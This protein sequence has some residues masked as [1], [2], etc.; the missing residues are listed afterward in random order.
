MPERW[1]RS[2]AAIAIGIVAVV[3]LALW[4]GVRVAEI[5]C[6][7]FDPNCGA[8]FVPGGRQRPVAYDIA[9]LAY[10]A[11]LFAAGGM[12]T[13]ALA[14]SRRIE[15]AFVVGVAAGT[16]LAATTGHFAVLGRFAFACTVIGAALLGGALAP[17]R[18]PPRS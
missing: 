8:D 18:L 10:H 13:A 3:T 6:Y 14:P 7:A 17:R 11:A 2:L 15:H 12:L 1:R 16:M 5:A 4:T 9:G